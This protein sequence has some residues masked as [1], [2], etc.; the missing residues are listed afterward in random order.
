ME[1]IKINNLVKKYQIADSNERLVL[2]NISICF[3]EK[4]LFALV[5]KSG[6]GKSTLLNMISALDK[7]TSGQI[8]YQGNDVSK[9]SNTK[10]ERYRNQDIGIVFQHYH[11][12]E[13]ESV[14]FNIMLPALIQ[15]KSE[16]EAEFAAKTLLKSINFKVNLYN[17]KCCDLSGGEKER[18]AI[19]RALINNPKILL[20]DEPTGALDS[21]NSKLVMDI[22]KQISKER[23]VIMVT[24]SIDLVKRYS[25]KII[26]L[27][28]GR[29][30]FSNK[31][32]ISRKGGMRNAQCI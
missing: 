14:L 20:A 9:W 15:G 32:D 29:V 27:Q 3:P 8:F 10:I 19:L 18:V 11:L 26:H 22:F 1:L 13:N 30:T 5:G 24:H 21:E 28:D 2:D 25:D 31:R 23:L 12:L 4:G 16:K 17:Q 7:P 6:S